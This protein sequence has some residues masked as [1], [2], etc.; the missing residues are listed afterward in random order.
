MIKEHPPRWSTYTPSQTKNQM[1]TKLVHQEILHPAIA[2][3]F[4]AMAKARSSIDRDQ[5]MSGGEMT[6]LATN[7]PEDHMIR[8]D[9]KEV[10]VKTVRE[11][12]YF[13]QKDYEDDSDD[14]EDRID[15][16]QNLVDSTS[17]CPHSKSQLLILSDSHQFL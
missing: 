8:F 17:L 2:A 15:N 10:T 14:G 6:T 11:P 9:I 12:F 4:A 3:A 7:A 1:M 16:P 13:L 5:E